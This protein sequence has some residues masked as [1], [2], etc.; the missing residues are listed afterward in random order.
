MKIRKL[1]FMIVLVG[2][3]A[4]ACSSG[5]EKET[6]GSINSIQDAIAALREQGLSVTQGDQFEQPFFSVP[7]VL[8]DLPGSGI[9]VFEYSDEAAAAAD[10]EQVAADGSSV[11]T[12]MP[13]W[14]DDPHF[15]REGKL[16]V[17]YL[18]SDQ[19]I[20]EA[21]EAVFGSQFAGR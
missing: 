11:G 9:Q 5:G 20:L 12:S 4:A 3:V 17:L 18:G 16:I 19:V 6:A 7:A 10:A 8:L 2:L 13:F 15:Y 14:V 1:V 21:L